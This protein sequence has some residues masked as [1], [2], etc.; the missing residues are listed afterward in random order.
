[1]NRTSTFK[2]ASSFTQEGQAAAAVILREIV[3]VYSRGNVRDFTEK[4][5][6]SIKERGFLRAAPLDTST[7]FRA[8]NHGNPNV[9]SGRKN[10]NPQFFEYFEPFLPEDFSI[11]DMYAIASG[12]Q[13]PPPLKELRFSPLTKKAHRYPS[14][15]SNNEEKPIIICL[16]INQSSYS[17]LN[18]NDI[19]C[20]QSNMSIHELSRP[21]LSRLSRLFNT[22]IRKHD[23]LSANTEL[24]DIVLRWAEQD[25]WFGGFSSEER[26]NLPEDVLATFAKV[27]FKVI[28]WKDDEPILSNEKYNED[29]QQLLK[30]TCCCEE[31]FISSTTY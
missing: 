11:E 20:V 28:E 9:K 30:D 4:L 26:A 18:A 24:P 25:S 16:I 1:M 13:E 27:C 19:S 12:R 29:W 2:K 15:N 6:K 7:V 10:I 14:K 5:N 21:Q 17:M 22:S 31:C 3:A 8:I 23:S